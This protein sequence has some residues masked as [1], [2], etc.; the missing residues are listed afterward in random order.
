MKAAGIFK[1]NQITETEQEELLKIPN[2]GRIVHQIEQVLAKIEIK[3]EKSAEDHDQTAPLRI[4]QKRPNIVV[5][6]NVW[7]D[8]LSPATNF[9][10]ASYPGNLAKFKSKFQVIT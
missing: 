6:S 10:S 3:S 7:I 1:I 4:D 2:L 9:Y 8:K 5:K